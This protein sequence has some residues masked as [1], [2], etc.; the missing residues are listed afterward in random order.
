MG[1]WPRRGEVSRAQGEAQDHALAIAH[2][3]LAVTRQWRAAG[4]QREAQTKEG[5]AR[6]GDLYVSEVRRRWILEWGT[7][8]WA[9]ST[10]LTTRHSCGS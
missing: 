10:A 2:E 1:A 6:V 4:V 3:N 7:N 9:R 5:M 8:V